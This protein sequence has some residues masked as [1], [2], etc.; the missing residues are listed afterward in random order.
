MTI[1]VLVISIIVMVS[2]S[3]TVVIV[4]RV[5]NVDVGCYNC[6]GCRRRRIYD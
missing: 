5:I 6:C 4:R 3:G 2:I 1:V